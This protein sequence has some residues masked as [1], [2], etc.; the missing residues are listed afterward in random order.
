MEMAPCKGKMRQIERGE[1][2]RRGV[3]NRGSGE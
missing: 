3:E 1:R 2:E